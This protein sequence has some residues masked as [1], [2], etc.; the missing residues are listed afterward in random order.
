M[1]I[2]DPTKIHFLRQRRLHLGSFISVYT[3]K[4][5]QTFCGVTCFLRRNP[6][7]VWWIFAGLGTCKLHFETSTELD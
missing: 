5:F 4:T 6:V 1:Q 7:N 2:C 3:P